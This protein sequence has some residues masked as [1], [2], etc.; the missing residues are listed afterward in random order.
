MKDF[1]RRLLY[2]GLILLGIALVALGAL[3]FG[4]GPTGIIA[5]GAFRTGTAWTGP[6][7]DWQA[8]RDRDTVQ[9]QLLTPARSRTTWVMVHNGRVFIPSGYM[10]SSFGRLWKQWP[11]EAERD[12]RA[13]LRV[14]GTIYERTLVRITD[15]PALPAVVGELARKYLGAPPGS[16]ERQ[17]TVD[18]ALAQVTAGALWIFEVVPRSGAASAPDPKAQTAM[19][20]ALRPTQQ[21]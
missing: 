12:G 11:P 13:R 8:L 16:P 2:A 19:P 14:D 1:A 10:Q 7:P 4:D 17:T 18:A 6:E 15:D 21:P 3:R 5:G 9:F 20:D